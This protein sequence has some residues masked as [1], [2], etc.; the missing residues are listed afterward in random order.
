MEIPFRQALFLLIFGTALYHVDPL[1]YSFCFPLASLSRF[2][3]TWKIRKILPLR[4]E[5][6][7]AKTAT[8][9][10]SSKGGLREESVDIHLLVFLLLSHNIVIG[11][12]DR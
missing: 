5:R 1:S 4:K 2:C 9:E 12:R 3:T 6:R 8:M 10:F 11:D 7:K